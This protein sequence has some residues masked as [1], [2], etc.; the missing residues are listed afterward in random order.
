MD[1]LTHLSIQ[2][3]RS[4]RDLD[5]LE[6]GPL[7]V[8]IGAN[9][10]GKSNFI[11]F[12]KMLNWMTPSLGNLQFY[13]EKMGG[14]NSLL[15]DG[16]SV[17]PQMKAS[18]VFR[19]DTGTNEYSFR[20][21]HA[22]GDTLI[23]SDEQFRYTPK[24]RTG[25][26][27]WVRLGAGHREAQII[28]KADGDTTAKFILSLMK[29]C[30]VYQFHNTS[31]TARIRQKW[32]VND[33]RFLKEDGANLAPFLLR[34]RDYKSKYYLRIVETIR[35][36]APFFAD[37]V[38]EPVGNAVLLQW[39]EKNSDLVFGS[40]QASDGTLRAMSLIALLLQP[41]DELP[42][43]IILDEPELGLHPFAIEIISGLLHSVSMHTQVILATQS[44]TLIDYFEPHQVIV[45]D[46][47]NRQSIFTRPDEAALKDWLAEYS[48]TELWQKN[49]IGGRPAR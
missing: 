39:R 47:P 17:T 5:D 43:V 18:L 30:V 28:K 40:H 15:H 3:F 1:L 41:E 49:V 9:G 48:L 20:L 25:D 19:T 21:S 31:E 33:N 12:F 13:V 34:L 14:A 26:R 32:D 4:I 24:D 8:L 2:G 6:L 44:A 36:V 11:S 35:L 45:V 16:A 22:A 37:F 29:Q 10:S 7:N 42:K 38:L 23:F 27:N 46:R